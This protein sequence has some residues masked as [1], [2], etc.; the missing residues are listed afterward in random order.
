VSGLRAF[1]GWVVLFVLVSSVFVLGVVAV[2]GKDEAVSAVDG[3]AEAVAEAYS[4]VWEAERAGANVSWLLTRL[5]GA[6]AYLA[7]ARMCLRMG[8][9]EAA[10]DNAVFC[11]GALDGVVEDAGA[12]R[13]RAVEEGGARSGMTISMSV[14]A[15][16]TVAATC[17]LG[18][19]LFKERYHRRALEMRPEV[20]ESES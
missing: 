1:L 6:G 3:A 20:I 17:W 4:A 13:D 14:V 19:N 2:D 8:D 7:L 18:W 12:L 5:D 16:L 10:V 9:F 11:I 15:V